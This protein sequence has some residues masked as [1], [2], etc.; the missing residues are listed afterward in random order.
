MMLEIQRQKMSGVMAQG[1][2]TVVFWVVR[3][4]SPI[5]G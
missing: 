5:G 3:L 4:S 1:I 2:H